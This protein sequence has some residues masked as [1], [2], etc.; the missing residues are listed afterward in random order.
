MTDQACDEVEGSYVRV[1]EQWR[2]QKLSLDFLFF[3]PEEMEESLRA[4]GF[5]VEEIAER[6]PWLVWSSPEST[7][8]SGLT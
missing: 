4:A 8:G 5:V 7:A 2:G 1:A 3:R 6:E